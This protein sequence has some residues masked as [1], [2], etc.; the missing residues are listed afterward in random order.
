M[1]I[2]VHDHSRLVL[3]LSDRLHFTAS[4][5]C[6]IKSFGSLLCSNLIVVLLCPSKHSNT[7]ALCVACMSY[8][9]K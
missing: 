9:R 3:G 6:D 7:G 4:S 8:M 1:F 5:N 2:D